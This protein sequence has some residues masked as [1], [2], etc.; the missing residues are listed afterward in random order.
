[1]GDEHGLKFIGHTRCPTCSFRRV[2]VLASGRLFMHSR[3][4]G[5]ALKTFV[6]LVG[7][8]DRDICPGSGE[9]VW[10]AN[11]GGAAVRARYRRLEIA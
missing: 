8:G 5:Y 2:G 10:Y 7:Y 4:K 9:R 3:G 6:P 11:D 1:M